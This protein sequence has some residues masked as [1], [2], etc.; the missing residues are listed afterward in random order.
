MTYSCTDTDLL[1]CVLD[2]SLTFSGLQVSSICNEG[3]GFDDFG[4]YN[5]MHPKN[6]SDQFQAQLPRACSAQVKYK[7]NLFHPWVNSH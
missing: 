2:Q 4:L 5:S 3:F 6:S 7:L 1:L